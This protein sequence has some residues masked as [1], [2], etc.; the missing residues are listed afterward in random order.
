MEVIKLR[1][2]HVRHVYWA[3]TGELES[4]V[5]Y[6]TSEMK[7]MDMENI[8]RILDNPQQLVQITWGRDTLCSRCPY[9]A[10]VSDSVIA[11][12]PE[13]LAYLLTY[14]L[15]SKVGPCY[16]GGNPNSK[17]DTADFELEY[18]NE[19]GIREI[20]DGP[21]IPADQLIKRLVMYDRAQGKNSIE[22]QFRERWTGQRKCSDS[23][24]PTPDAHL[25]HHLRELLYA[26]YHSWRHIS[27]K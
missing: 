11:D 4:H 24:H 23:A 14:G 3:M 20:L 26:T 25:L 6:H 21:P 7:Q 1:P 13:E 12:H 8:H 16:K 17:S 27:A 22:P 19:F 15:S 10:D 2:H 5:R 9:N 18:A